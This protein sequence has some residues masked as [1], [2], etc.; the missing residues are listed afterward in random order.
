MREQLELI[1][2]AFRCGDAAAEENRWEDVEDA[3]WQIT[4]APPTPEV[5]KALVGVLRFKGRLRLAPSC[6]LPHSMPPEE[7]L[8][9]LAL[10]ALGKWTGVAYLP[11]MQQVAATTS[12]PVLAGIAK[13]VIREATRAQG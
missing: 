5:E 7:M 8:K 9:S 13:A 2:R 3:L 4:E 10:Q 11:E 12:S 6:E 1:R